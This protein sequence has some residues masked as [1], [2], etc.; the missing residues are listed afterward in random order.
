MAEPP[1]SWSGIE[2]RLTF[3]RPTP[4]AEP[5]A[6]GRWRLRWRGPALMGVLNVTPDSFSDGGRHRDASAAVEAGLGLWREGAA[7]VDVG[8]ESSRPGAEGVPAAEE[9]RRVLP[10][11]A[12]LSAAGVSV[13]IDTVKPEVAREALAAGACLVNDIRGLRDEAMRRVCAEAGAPAVLMHMQGEPR[14]MQRAPHY[15]DVV[16]EVEAFLL[17]NARRALDEGVPAVAIDPGVGFGKTVAHNL[18]LL[19]ATA[20]L[21]GHGLPLLVGASRKSMIGKLVGEL[22]PSERLPGTLALHVFAAERGAALLRVHDVAEHAQALAVRAALAG[23]EGA[24]G[25]G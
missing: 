15:D 16:D 19:A 12:G 23:A 1:A 17:A 14:S 21:A 22:G 6:A 20:R 2:H 7:F 8:G 25:H 5:E 3:T 11:V 9:L 18:A 4:G 13:S 24:E 10:V